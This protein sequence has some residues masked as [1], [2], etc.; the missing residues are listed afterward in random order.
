V[1]LTFG[2]LTAGAAAFRIGDPPPPGA[3]SLATRVR[4]AWT[5]FA[6]TGDPGW[7]AYEPR[8]RHTW[9]IDADPAVAPYPEEI[10]RRLWA[11]YPFAPVGLAV[12]APSGSAESASPTLRPPQTAST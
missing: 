6:A 2:N 1:P 4:A 5:T 10:S 8:E 9:I 11:S 7:P 12:T 3:A